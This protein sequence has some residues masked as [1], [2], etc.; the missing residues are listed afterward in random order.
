MVPISLFDRVKARAN[1]SY[2]KCNRSMTK[3]LIWVINQPAGKNMVN[4][5]APSCHDK[6]EFL[7]YSLGKGHFRGFDILSYRP[8]VQW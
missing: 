5:K 3:H 4:Q 2:G 6:E 7:E 8:T 1:V